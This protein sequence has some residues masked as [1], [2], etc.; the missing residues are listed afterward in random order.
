MPDMFLDCYHPYAAIRGLSRHG[1]LL[2]IR[3]R[4]LYF[5]LFC[6]FAALFNSCL[7]SAAS[8]ASCSAFSLSVR[9]FL[10]PCATNKYFLCTS[11]GA[12]EGQITCWTKDLVL[13]QLPA[14]SLGNGC[15]CGGPDHY[16]RH[17]S[18]SQAFI[19]V[20]DTRYVHLKWYLISLRLCAGQ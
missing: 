7:V 17:S 16:W 9:A 20:K 19:K 18:F 1:I 10:K 14:S 12:S 2:S 3:F 4:S 6:G 15:S 5:G 13:E 11:R 8:L